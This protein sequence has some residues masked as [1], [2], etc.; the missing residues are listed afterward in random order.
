MQ[1]SPLPPDRATTQQSLAQSEVLGLAWSFRGQRFRNNSAP[2]TSVT[3]VMRL[4]H[5]L[6]WQDHHYYDGD[7]SLKPVR[8]LYRSS[9][10]RNDGR[11]ARWDSH[12]CC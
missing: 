9:S 8:G 3:W 7:L 4:V 1:E 11:M 6:E 10:T 12:S 5:T 2:K